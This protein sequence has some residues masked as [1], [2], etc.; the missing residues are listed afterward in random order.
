L[1]GPV[2]YRFRGAVG[3]NTGISPLRR[4]ERA[5]GRD[6]N[7]INREA[8]LF[9]CGVACGEVLGEDVGF[10]GVVL[11]GWEGDGVGAG[12]GGL[13]ADHGE[14]AVGGHVRE[15][16]GEF[17]PRVPDYGGFGFGLVDG[18]AALVDGVVDVHGDDGVEIGAV[19]FAGEFEKGVGLVFLL[20]VVGL[21]EVVGVGEADDGDLLRVADGEVGVEGFFKVERGVGLIGYGELE[22]EFCTEDELVGEVE[23]VVAEG[24]AGVVGT[25]GEGEMEVVAGESGEG[26]G[27]LGGAGEAVRGAVGAGVAGGCG[28]GSEPG[29]D[30]GDA[31]ADGFAGGVE[32][33]VGEEEHGLLAGG[34]PLREVRALE[35]ELGRAGGCGDVG[36]EETLLGL[37]EGEDAGDGEVVGE[38]LE[39]HRILSSK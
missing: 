13:D 20:E 10:H 17:G 15:F 23:A 6:D 33:A 29:E 34:L 25:E 7:S 2:S 35:V 38:G 16:G 27:P 39:G 22:A 24:V 30:D 12:V 31:A 26:E 19:G 1:F 37:G 21:V 32:G 11:A 18:D 4:K 36:A 9:F 28:A 3:R 8:V 14:P 5:F